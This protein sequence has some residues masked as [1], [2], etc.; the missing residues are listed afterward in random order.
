VFRHAFRN[1]LIPLITVIALRIPGLFA[2]SVIIEQVFN[3]PGLGTLSILSAI[4]QDYPVLMGLTL[5]FA[6]IIMAA[7]L[8]ADI[9]YAVADP[10]IRYD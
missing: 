1:G 8:L 3:W 10:R 2:G 9:T 4:A 6:V 7:N 5:S